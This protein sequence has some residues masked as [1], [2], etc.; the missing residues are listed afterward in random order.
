MLEDK[1]QD[2]ES[3]IWN[4]KTALEFNDKDI[5]TVMEFNVLGISPSGTSVARI[6][7]SEYAAEIIRNF[8]TDLVS[9]PEG[10]KM[11]ETIAKILDF[12]HLKD[13]DTTYHNYPCL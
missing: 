11:C 12:Y 3:P 7:G 4:F 2:G 13:D 1:E 10:G 8:T 9:L 6:H 5:L